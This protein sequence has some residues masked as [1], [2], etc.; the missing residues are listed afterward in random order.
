MTN[1]R[2]GRSLRTTAFVLR[3]PAAILQEV[4]WILFSSIIF[5]GFEKPF[6][7]ARSVETQISI[8]GRF[9]PAVFVA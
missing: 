3:F 9:I 2:A 4:S 5:S 7:S 8:T 1:L 6:L